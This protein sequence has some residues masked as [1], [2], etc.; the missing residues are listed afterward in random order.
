MYAI[1]LQLFIEIAGPRVNSPHRSSPLLHQCEHWSDLNGTFDEM[2]NLYDFGDARLTRRFFSD[3]P[4]H[5]VNREGD[6]LSNNVY[7]DRFLRSPK[8]AL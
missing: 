5:T 1:R 8:E 7:R 2:P 6:L 4:H 3:E